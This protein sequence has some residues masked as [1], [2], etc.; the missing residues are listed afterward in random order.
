MITI[1]A[2]EIHIISGTVDAK[3]IKLINCMKVS[4]KFQL[5]NTQKM[6]L[7]YH[8]HRKRFTG[9]Q[10]KRRICNKITVQ[11]LKINEDEFSRENSSVMF[12]FIP[13]DFLLSVQEEKGSHSIS[14]DAFF[15]SMR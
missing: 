8:Y 2:F 6:L 4:Y 15:Y 14:L 1:A 7:A 13:K 9:L 11:S 12:P 5:I 3:N 10:L